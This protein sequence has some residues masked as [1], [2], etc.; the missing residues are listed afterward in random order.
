MSLITDISDGLTLSFYFQRFVSDP[1]V[2][3]AR[4]S[5][6]AEYFIGRWAGQAIPYVG[7]D[8][9]IHNLIKYCKIYFKTRKIQSGANSIYR[10]AMCRIAFL[11]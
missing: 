4:H 1:A 2:R 3:K 11:G 8:G 9:T 5:A 10:R 7:K 6:I